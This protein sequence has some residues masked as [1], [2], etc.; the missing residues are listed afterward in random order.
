MG[1]EALGTTSGRDGVRELVSFLKFTGKKPSK[2]S[3]PKR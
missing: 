1:V 3:P 2:T